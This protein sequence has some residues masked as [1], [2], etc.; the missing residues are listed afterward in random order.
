MRVKLSP[1]KKIS[2]KLAFKAVVRAN[3]EGLMLEMSAS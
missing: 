2:K 1:E 3:D